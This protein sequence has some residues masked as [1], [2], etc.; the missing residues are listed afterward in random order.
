MHPVLTCRRPMDD[1]VRQAWDQGRLIDITTFGKKSGQP[2][3]LEIWFHNLDGTIYITGTPGKR[4]WYANLLVQPG[5]TF[6]LKEG[7]EADLPAVAAPIT[8]PA[9]RRRV[10]T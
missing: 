4:D 10:F 1:K 8:D 6:H 9:E 3:R 7:L 5:F 2:R